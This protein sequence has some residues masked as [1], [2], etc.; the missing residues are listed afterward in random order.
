MDKIA[1][2]RE[3]IFKEALTKIAKEKTEK[4][5][6]V[7]NAGKMIGKESLKDYGK[8]ERAKNFAKAVG[9]ALA[10]GAIGSAVGR[11]V[12][13]KITN[14]MM[15]NGD[16]LGAMLAR[17]IAEGALSNIGQIAGATIAGK[18]GKEKAKDAEINAIK[19][20]SDKLYGDNEKIKN[21]AMK[22]PNRL[23]GSY[24]ANLVKAE[25][26]YKKELKK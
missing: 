25:K 11:S 22:K 17:P 3:V 10:G 12:G 18:K 6:N 15:D 7:F 23:F 1:M 4:R 14:K 2:Y 19:R 26:A 16:D 9:G 20:L 24:A 21:I 5:P 8:K 13:N